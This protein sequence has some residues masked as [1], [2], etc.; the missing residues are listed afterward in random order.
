MHFLLF[1]SF[2]L[3]AS[4]AMPA[5]ERLGSSST[6]ADEALEQAAY[7]YFYSALS[8]TPEEHFTALNAHGKQINA[9]LPLHKAAWDMDR[10]AE[11]VE[12]LLAHGADPMALNRFETYYA[13][14]ALDEAIH[15]GNNAVVHALLQHEHTDPNQ[16]R[17]WFGY[18]HYDVPEIRSP[19]R[20]AV[21]SGNWEATQAL[22]AHP[23]LN[24]S[25]DHV[26]SYASRVPILTLLLRHPDIKVNGRD[27]RGRTALHAFVGQRPLLEHL[28]SDPR[29]N[30][31]VKD[32][33]DEDTALHVAAKTGDTGSARDLLSHPDID[34]QL[35]NHGGR[36]AWKEARRN[37]NVEVAALIRQHQRQRFWS[38]FRLFGRR[39][40]DDN[41]MQEGTLQV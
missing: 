26:L 8:D 33:F 19:L 28:L 7:P 30:V 25:H 21:E 6:D 23:K 27:V 3:A 34:T 39:N 10:G 29:V 16:G 2:I 9:E 41:M 37:G 14:T 35:Q 31:N 38:H 32:R 1:C 4:L 40:S 13:N 12:R 11:A 15:A 18:D 22:L 24:I 20:A 36:T 17:F 5:R